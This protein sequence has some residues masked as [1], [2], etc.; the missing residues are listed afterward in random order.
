MSKG[1][2]RSEIWI[3]S[4]LVLIG[5]VVGAILTL[6]AA[7]MFGYTVGPITTTTTL[8][9]TKTVFVTKTVITPTTMVIHRT[10]T[11]TDTVTLLRTIYV[12]ET[13]T[14]TKTVTVTKTVTAVTVTTTPTR[15]TTWDFE[16]PEIDELGLTGRII[17]LSQFSGKPVFLEFISPACSHCLEKTPMINELQTRYGDKVV[18]I[19]IVFGSVEAAQDLLQT[20]EERTWIHVLDYSGEVF[21]SYGIK[22]VPTYVILDEHHLERGRFYG[23]GT[24]L[25]DLEEIILRIIS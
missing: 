18:F 12:T 14:L 21:K 9:V 4:I 2:K 20:Y 15:I 23:A 7:Q 6:V 10:T 1:I 8:T 22:G 11:L 13:R 25:E 3:T 5:V 16:L 17:R 24:E 19:S